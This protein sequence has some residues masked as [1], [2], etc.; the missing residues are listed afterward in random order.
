MRIDGST[1]DGFDELE[2]SKA[3]YIARAI[4]PGR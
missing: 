2:N 1:T 3:V 4:V